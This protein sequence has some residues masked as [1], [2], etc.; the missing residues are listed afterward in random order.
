MLDRGGGVGL[1]AVGV[2]KQEGDRL[3]LLH[4]MSHKASNTPPFF[5]KR[6]ASFEFLEFV[7]E[8]AAAAAAAASF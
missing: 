1:V 6:V 2:L 3:V 5:K 8:A 7:S 4:A